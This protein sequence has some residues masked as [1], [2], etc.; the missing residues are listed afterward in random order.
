MA[1]SLG[2]G[3]RSKKGQASPIHPVS[4]GRFYNI[5]SHPSAMERFAARRPGDSKLYQTT[6]NCQRPPYKQRSLGED[7][8]DER[9][10]FGERPHLYIT[11][12]S[13]ET[14][15]TPECEGLHGKHMP[16]SMELSY[17]A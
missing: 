3:G 13:G 14:S 1:S 8:I 12:Q 6:R 4:S 9:G 16:P 2:I 5:P 17:A 10:R 11:L 7:G 15:E